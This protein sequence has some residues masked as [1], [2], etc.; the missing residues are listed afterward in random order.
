[1]ATNRKLRGY[2]ERLGFAYCGDTELLGAPGERLST[3]TPTVVSLFELVV[4][5]PTPPG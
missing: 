4:S 1:V 2:Y 3:G 5:G